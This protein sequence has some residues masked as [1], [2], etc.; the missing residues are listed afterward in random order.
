[1]TRMVIVTGACLLLSSPPAAR[2]QLLPSPNTVAAHVVVDG[3]RHADVAVPEGSPLTITTP[4]GRKIR[5]VPRRSGD[6]LRV[7]VIDVINL[8]DVPEAAQPA[9]SVELLQ[10][11]ETPVAIGRVPLLVTWT[12]I[13]TA[14]AAATGVQPDQPCSRCCVTCQGFTLCGCH[15]VMDC[16]FC[17]CPLTCSCDDARP[18]QS[19]VGCAVLAGGTER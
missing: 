12:G 9:G 4:D 2:A 8:P 19:S 14:T 13:G 17:C 7:E 18:G 11:T 6:N 5:L 15:I 10:N 16:G 1:M 3:I